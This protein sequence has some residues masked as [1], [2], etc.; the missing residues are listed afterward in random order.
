MCRSVPASLTTSKTTSG[1]NYDPLC[2]RFEKLWVNHWDSNNIDEM[3]TV[4]HELENNYSDR[5]DPYLW[6]GKCYYVKGLHDLK[7]RAENNKIAEKYAVKAHETDPTSY[8]AFFNLLNALSSRESTDYIFSNYGEWIKSMSPLPAAELIPDM[9]PSEEWNEAK[10]LWLLNE[11]FQKFTL[12]IKK[13]ELI[14]NKNPDDYYAQLWACYANLNMGEYYLFNGD[15]KKKIPFYDK[16]LEFCSRALAMDPYN[17]RAHFWYQLTLS[18]KIQTASIFTKAFHFK[19]I[20]DHLIFCVRENALYDSSGPVKVLATMIIEGG[21]VCEKGMQM[22]GYT[23]E[24]VITFLQVSAILYPE[25]RYI[26]YITARLFEREKKKNAA[27]E[28]LE[29]SLKKGPP[30]GNRPNFIHE[31]NSY[32]NLKN[33]YEKLL[34]RNKN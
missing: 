32:H 4:L 14:A 30:A 25:D 34:A 29:K 33:L 18:R 24:M 17:Y 16:A 19:T 5:I 9:M 23:I 10:R 22:A 2:K 28:V 27:L 1:G 21:W 7:S 13:F 6:L 26:P 8:Y 15:H 12:A 20:M 3:L 31:M 11:D